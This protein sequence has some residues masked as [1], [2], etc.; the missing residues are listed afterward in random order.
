MVA[1]II[2]VL[3]TD[4]YKLTMQQAVW[5][6]PKFK[7]ATA[8]Y[9]FNNR[10]TDMLFTVECVEKFRI[11]VN[12][13]AKL[14]LTSKEK[15]WLK[16]TC[17]YFG[18]DYLDW[19]Q[20]YRFKPD[21]VT[22]RLVP[23][24]DDPTWGQIEMEA[25]G[26]WVETILWEIP[27]MSLL[28]ETYFL[29]VDTTW[30]DENQ[31]VRAYEKGKKLLEEGCI[32]SEFGT[33]RRRSFKTQDDV[34]AGLIRANQEPS[35]HSNGGKLLGTS[36]VYLA[37]KYDLMP[38]GTI[39]HEW[40]MAVAAIYGY[41]GCNMRALSLWEQAYSAP[42][43]SSLYISLT[44]T[45]ST[46]VFFREFV[47]SPD[48]ARKWRLRQDSGDPMDFIRKAKQAYDTLGI[49]PKEKSIIFSDSLNLDKAIKIKNACTEAGL[50]AGFGIGTYL[51]NDFQKADGGGPSRALNMV[52]KLRSINDIPC[53]KISDEVGKHTG[54]VEAVDEVIRLLHIK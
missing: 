45:F 4:L 14:Q 32:F 31:E 53:V 54:Q 39:A 3:D 52:I 34:L 15:V 8:R 42:S 25:V 29:I 19:L 1:D 41:E 43:G 5:R 24:D 51:S 21:Q 2:S 40:F 37:I 17:P 10:S 35:A 11:V 47:N 22:V 28:S 7:D 30:K 12:N 18:D 49:D 38:I 20:E 26:P 27:L 6:Q 13:L 46:D 9:R 48:H 16:K 44:D 33:R 36:N 50:S 23:S